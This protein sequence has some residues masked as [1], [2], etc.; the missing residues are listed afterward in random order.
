MLSLRKFLTTLSVGSLSLFTC[1]LAIAEEYEKGAY[2]SI[3]FGIGKFSEIEQAGGLPNIETEAGFSF[4]GSIGYDFGKNFRTDISY[5]K[6]KSTIVLAAGDKDSDFGSIMLNAYI[7]FPIENSKWEPFIG[8]GL[9]MTQ[10]DLEETCTAAGNTECTDDVFTYGL[11]GGINYNLNPTTAITAKIT[12][13]GFDDITITNQGA[14]TII[15]DSETIATRIG[16]KF[17][18]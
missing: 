15:T 14:K 8:A 4:E 2:A 13:L 7:D 16:M 6:T 18:F 17:K 10:A 1:N 9:G 3:D 11:S 12:Y 5:T